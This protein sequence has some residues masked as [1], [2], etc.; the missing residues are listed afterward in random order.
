MPVWPRGFEPLAVD[1]VVDYITEHAG[2]R[3]KE[4]DAIDKRII[5]DFL[6]RKGQILDSQDE[7]GGYPVHKATYRKLDIPEEAIDCWLVQL[8][9]ELEN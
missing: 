5:Q 3:P 7:V 4:R 6:E 1:E 9:S 2:A 8:A